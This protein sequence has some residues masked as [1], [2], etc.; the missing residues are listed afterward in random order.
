MIELTEEQRQAVM[1]GQTVHM[2]PAEI[3]K[4]VVLL[5]E[6]QYDNLRQMLDE[7]QEDRKLQKGWQKLAFRGLA[8]SQ[9]D[10]P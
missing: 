8:L 6:E 5:L 3:G 7:E 4:S 10:E 2:Q 9:D 1:H